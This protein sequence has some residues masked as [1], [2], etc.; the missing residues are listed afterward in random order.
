MMYSSSMPFGAGGVNVLGNL[1]DKM[2][3]QLK[4][5]KDIETSFDAD[6]QT[7]AKNKMSKK[8]YVH[9]LVTYT[10][11]LSALNFLV[12]HVVLEMRTAIDEGSPIK[13]TTGGTVLAEASASGPE[14][15][16]GIQGFIGGSYG[17]SQVDTSGGKT[18]KDIK[19]YTDTVQPVPMRSNDSSSTKGCPNCG[20]VVSQMA[21][22][23]RTCGQKQ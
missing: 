1:T 15:G 16:L 21:K 17:D 19:N 3:Q 6:F 23:C 11:S 8:E 22:F 7:Y 20:S 14:L 18:Q 12:M 10:I 5:T 4:D 2:M 13:D 9:K